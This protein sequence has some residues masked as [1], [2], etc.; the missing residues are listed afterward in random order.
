MIALPGEWDAAVAAWLA[1]QVLVRGSLILLAAL[2]ATRLLPRATAGARSALWMLAVGALALGPALERL[3][4]AP[5]RGD[6]GVAWDAGRTGVSDV[7]VMPAAAVPAGTARGSWRGAYRPTVPDAWV[8]VWLAGAALL[9]VRLAVHARLAARLAATSQPADPRLVAVFE[10]T[11][12]EVCPGRHVALREH[13][14]AW[15]PLVVGGRRPVVLMP[16]RAAS[17]PADRLRSTFRHELAHVVRHDYPQHVAS[18]VV[19]ALYWATPLAWIARR[20]LDLEREAACDERV[21]AWGTSPAA[22]AQHLLD[23]ARDA[24]RSRFATATAFA[25]RCPHLARRVR[26]VLS[27]RAG[28]RP[29]GGVWA[30]VIV[31]A[32]I[33]TGMI[34]T[35]EL[36]Q[37]RRDARR[38]T[39]LRHLA[40]PAASERRHGAWMLGEL[41]SAR[42]VGVLVAA[43]GDVAAEVRVA[44]AWALGEIKDPATGAAVAASLDDPDARVREMAALAIGEIGDPA[45]VEPL[46]AAAALHADLVGPVRWALGEIG[47]APLL[48]RAGL[49]GDGSLPDP[50][51]W[52]GRFT[53]AGET[54]SGPVV[55][56]P[57]VTELIDELR[58]A[59][60]VRRAAAAL[61]LGRAGDERAVHPLLDALQDS[62][63][64]VW[65]AAVWALDEINPSR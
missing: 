42:D 36:V 55:E 9:V 63:P 25:E 50:N 22:Y 52:A 31:L 28:W 10:A 19:L 53:V 34:S 65:A 47:G 60:A 61:A 15:I 41:E 39:A 13:A 18:S 58:A 40:G 21:I 57:S 27:A 4:E 43:L 2:V 48:A 46:R 11:R 24:G 17:W 54:A 12:G 62:S 26:S 30:S 1:N 3:T 44:A 45:G 33:G 14:D 37:T 32:L 8:W 49:P 38:D 51:A 6:G 56:A 29:A 20:F 16:P 7:V 35:L 59:D 23:V 5:D 64:E